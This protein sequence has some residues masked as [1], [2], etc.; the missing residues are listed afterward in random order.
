MVR[1]KW[2]TGHDET[3]QMRKSGGKPSFVDLRLYCSCVVA[4]ADNVIEQVVEIV[5]ERD[6]EKG[7]SMRYRPSGKRQSKEFYQFISVAIDFATFSLIIPIHQ[8]DA[9]DHFVR[10]I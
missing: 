4:S 9:R 10:P 8:S 1:G 2:Q 3:Q 5:V 7:G 6:R